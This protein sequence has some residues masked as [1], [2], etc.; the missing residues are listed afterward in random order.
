MTNVSAI[1]R[2]RLAAIVLASACALA[3]CA[4]RLR[5][6]PGAPAEPNLP[7]GQLEAG[8]W[9]YLF[10][11]ELEDPDMIAR[12][13]GAARVTSPDSARLDFFLAGNLASGAA[14]LID[15]LLRLPSRTEAFSRRLVPEPPLLWASLG[16]LAVPA[17]ADT[18]AGAVGDTLRADIGR[19]V[20]WRVTFVR[21]MLTSVERVDNGRL[22]EWVRRYPD[23]RVVYRHET[24]RRR[25]EL[26]V[27]KVER[28]SAF[29]ASIWDLR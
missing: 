4:P 25:L 29:D 21:E 5:P 13:E 14:V 26:V 12:G 19:P 9:R 18:L 3:A 2:R 16:R 6:L 15:S 24:S 1:S 11:W 27:T 22:M 7:S 23:G 20:Q 28:T 17:M 8:S 10:R